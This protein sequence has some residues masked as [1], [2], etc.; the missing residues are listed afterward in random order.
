LPEDNAAQPESDLAISLGLQAGVAR[1]TASSNFLPTT[2]DDWGPGFGASIAYE[3]SPAPT[4]I[5]FCVDVLLDYVVTGSQQAFVGMILW[6]L[7]IK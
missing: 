3:M 2:Q 4:G 7:V 1:M 6:G 5:S